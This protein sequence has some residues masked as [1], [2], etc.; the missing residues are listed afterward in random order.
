MPLGWKAFLAILGWVLPLLFLL[1]WAGR[2]ETKPAIL[3][4]RVIYF[5]YLALLG[6]AF[7]WFW[8]GDGEIN[9]WLVPL[10]FLAGLIS[11]F[12][13][14]KPRVCWKLRPLELTL[15]LSALAALLSVGIVFLVHFALG[16]PLVIS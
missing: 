1:A 16:R 14:A 9:L 10:S 11:L 15:M 5:P 2:L 12:R 3:V 13:Y 4:L 6:F 7:Y 8:G